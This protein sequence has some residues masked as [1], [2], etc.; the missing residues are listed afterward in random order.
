MWHGYI[1]FKMTKNNLHMR[2]VL[3]LF[4][5]LH[6]QNPVFAL[7]WYWGNLHV[8]GLHVT[9]NM[10]KN[11]DFRKRKL[12]LGFITANPISCSKKWSVLD[13]FALWFSHL[14]FYLLWRH[15]G[16]Q[17]NYSQKQYL[18]AAQEGVCFASVRERFWVFFKGQYL[19]CYCFFFWGRFF[20]RLL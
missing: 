5:N 9:G 3:I 7:K 17:S 12:V 13:G 18:S 2:D 20:W 11:R 15:T 8:A 6:L 4:K 10:L 1:A 14:L 16:I 19:L